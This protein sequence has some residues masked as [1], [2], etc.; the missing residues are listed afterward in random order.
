M[1][2]VKKYYR[3][4]RKNIS[5]IKFIVEACEGLAVVSTEDPWMGILKFSIA[6]GCENEFEG[7]LEGMAREMMIQK[8]H[9]PEQPMYSGCLES[10][11]K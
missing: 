11:T 4:D 6:P 2:T 5:L 1:Q 10:A 3:V 8:W 7:I 9:Q